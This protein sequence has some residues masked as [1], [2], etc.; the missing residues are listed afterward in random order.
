MTC[1]CIKEKSN[2]FLKRE[3]CKWNIDTASYQELCTD[4]TTT[5][6]TTT[7]TS[8]TTTTTT[9]TTQ[10]PKLCSPLDNNHGKWKCSDGFNKGSMCL[11]NC[12]DN[13]HHVPQHGRKRKCKCKTYKGGNP[14][15]RPWKREECQ[16]S[17]KR[18]KFN[19]GKFPTCEFEAPRAILKMVSHHGG[20][21][22]SSVISHTESGIQI[23]P[24]ENK[25]I[26]Q[27]GNILVLE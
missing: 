5:T 10:P 16:W 19:Q 26:R 17:A 20:N 13:Y 25:K 4:A 1:S 23:T 24:P 3:K 12:N 18:L 14:K 22:Q 2:I 11:L 7:T 27:V 9:T 21:H 15:D 6:T 8:T